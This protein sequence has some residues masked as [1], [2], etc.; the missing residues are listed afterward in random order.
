MGQHRCKDNHPPIPA[1]WQWS[2]LGH[3]L[4]TLLPTA[5]LEKIATFKENVQRTHQNTH[6]LQS[7]EHVCVARQICLV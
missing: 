4:N 6:T 3:L 1:V 5:I 7:T 2:I